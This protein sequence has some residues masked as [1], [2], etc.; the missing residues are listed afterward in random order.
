MTD[1]LVG[2]RFG[3]LTV[4]KRSEDHVTAGGRKLV[5]YACVCDCGNEK[6]V[7]ADKLRKGSTRSCGCI[8]REKSK[9]SIKNAANTAVENKRKRRA[10]LVG[11]R[12]G[13]LTV[14]SIDGADNNGMYRARCRCDCG[15]VCSIT[16]NNLVCGRSTQCKTCQ[17]NELNKNFRI[18]EMVDGTAL[19]KLTQKKRCDNTTG[20]KGVYIDK[21]TGKFV[22]EIK[23]RGKKYWIGQ[24][25][26]LEDAKKAREQAEQELFDPILKAHGRPLTKNT[27][28]PGGSDHA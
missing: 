18:N 1:D 11:K 28:T 25:S 21:R 20:V 22:A 13:R 7:R 26:R 10:A 6:I 16:I 23:L 27:Q 12:F 2:Q 3:R 15:E 17:L 9:I 19:C 4:L 14:L 5:T 24:Y 8:V